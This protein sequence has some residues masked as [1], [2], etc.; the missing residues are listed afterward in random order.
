MR[1]A[2]ALEMATHAPGAV[3][4]EMAEDDGIR[5]GAMQGV[6][7]DKETAA[8]E[9]ADDNRFASALREKEEFG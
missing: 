9:S 8:A 2:Q 7:F 6:S 4:S 5:G 3:A 1:R